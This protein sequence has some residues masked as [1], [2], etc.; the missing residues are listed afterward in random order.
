LALLC[1]VRDV[2]LL[3]KDRMVLCTDGFLQSQCFLAPAALFSTPGGGMLLRVRARAGSD[4]GHEDNFDGACD[5]NLD[6]LLPVTPEVT[7]GC[8]PVLAGT[9]MCTG[10]C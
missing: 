4:V 10:S 7:F 1:K 6:E 3:P 2:E 8:I 9:P 5:I